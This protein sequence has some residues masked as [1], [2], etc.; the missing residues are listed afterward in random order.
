M[1]RFLEKNA[2][3]NFDGKL[4]NQ[5]PK[6]GTIAQDGTRNVESVGK[7]SIPPGWPPPS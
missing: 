1:M 2:Q 4:L 5:L 7:I 6:K 3:K